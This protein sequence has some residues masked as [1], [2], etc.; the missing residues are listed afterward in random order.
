M[1]VFLS[2]SDFTGAEQPLQRF[3][4][5]QLLLVA[6][7][8]QAVEQ[9]RGDGGG[10]LQPV[11]VAGVGLCAEKTAQQPCGYAVSIAIGHEKTIGITKQP[12]QAR[13]VAVATV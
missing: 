6:L 4:A 3:E 13:V 8:P 5:I 11:T 9:G 2:T 10:Q 1:G 7:F 12:L